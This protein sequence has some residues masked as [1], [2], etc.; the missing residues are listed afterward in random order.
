L[1]AT[2]YSFSSPNIGRTASLTT[3]TTVVIGPCLAQ[4]ALHPLKSPRTPCSTYSDLS[5]PIIVIV[6]PS[7]MN[8][9]VLTTSTGAITV[10]VTRPATPLTVRC[11]ESESSQWSV[12]RKYCL[13][14]SYVAH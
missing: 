11:V 9:R 8:I 1:G 13:T 14:S 4:F 10:V 12:C 5:V 6:V 7:A 3:N 2:S